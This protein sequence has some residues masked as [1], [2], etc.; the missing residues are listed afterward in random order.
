[1]KEPF[2]WNQLFLYFVFW[3]PHSLDEIKK[4]IKYF[5]YDILFIFR[6]KMQIICWNF[7]FKSSVL[8]WTGQRAPLKFTRCTRCTVEIKTQDVHW[9]VQHSPPQFT[10]TKIIILIQ[11]NPVKG[12]FTGLGYFNIWNEAE[13]SDWTVKYSLFSLSPSKTLNY[14]GDPSPFQINI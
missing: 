8:S 1:M 4:K 14:V 10:E 5:F 12:V 3:A 11:K 2:L 9:T 6:V 7:V 13:L